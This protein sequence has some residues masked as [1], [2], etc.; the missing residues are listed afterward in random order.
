MWSLA[1]LRLIPIA[2]F[3]IVNLVAGASGVRLRQF[4]AGTLIG[5]G[6]GIVLICLSVDRARAAISGDPVFEPW[7]VA[8]IAAAGASLILLRARRL[9]SGGRDD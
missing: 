7:I 5:M 9:K 1:G 3:T 4:L 6:P 8:A 2:P